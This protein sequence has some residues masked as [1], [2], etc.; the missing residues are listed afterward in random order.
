MPTHPTHLQEGQDQRSAGKQVRYWSI[1]TAGAIANPPLLPTDS[2]CLFDQEVPTSSA[3][4][5]TVV[6]SLPQDRPKN[7]KPGAESPG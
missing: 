4:E 3:G 6:V 7:A 2:A 1:C 5:Y